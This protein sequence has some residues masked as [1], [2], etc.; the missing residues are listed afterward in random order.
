[1]KISKESIIRITFTV[2]L[3][4][5]FLFANIYTFRQLSRT[6]LE[7]YFYDKLLVAYQSA[8]LAGFNNELERMLL[9]DKMPKEAVLAKEFQANLNKI[10]PVD[11]F[12]KEV[13]QDKK[14]RINHLNLMRRIAFIL[15]LL[16]ISFRLAVNLYFRKR[17]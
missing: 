10:G 14:M 17:K 4:L 5:L 2:I 11:K 15:I 16:I 9:E 7:L 1:M 13:I 6:G 8:G 12:L 3:L